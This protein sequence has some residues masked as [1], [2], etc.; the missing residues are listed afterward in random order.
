MSSGK[1]NIASHGSTKQCNNR[2]NQI[3]N[4][5]RRYKSVLQ[6]ISH[7]W[8]DYNNNAENNHDHDASQ[9]LGQGIH[10][11]LGILYQ[12]YR[13]GNHACQSTADLGRNPQQSVKAQ[14]TATHVADIKRQSAQGYH[15]C[16]KVSQSRK[17]LVR[18][19]L[20]AHSRHTQN[21][22]DIHLGDRR[23]NNGYQNH[24][25]KASLMRT[26]KLSRLGQKARSDG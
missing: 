15:E 20:P 11:S 10:G 8:P 21:P 1:G 13:D 7:R 9:H 5:C 6:R 17:H 4:P 14:R 23:Q 16:H 19:I 26:C 18:H 3:R 24:E 25:T 22:P 2:R 12:K